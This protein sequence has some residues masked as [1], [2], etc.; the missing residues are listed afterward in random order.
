[1]ADSMLAASG[2]EGECRITAVLFDSDYEILHDR[3]DIRT[4][5]NYEKEYQVGG[6][7]AAAPSAGPF[8]NRWCAKAHCED[9]RAQK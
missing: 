2:A 5:S 9:Y 6:T 1:M 8:I 3:I 7:T 4:W